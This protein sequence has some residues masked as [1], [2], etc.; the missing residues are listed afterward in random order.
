MSEPINYDKSDSSSLGKSYVAGFLKILRRIKTQG[1][2][3]RDMIRGIITN[4]KYKFVRYFAP[5]YFNMPQRAGIFSQAMIFS[6]ST[7]IMI[8]KKLQILRIKITVRQIL[9]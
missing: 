1:S 9:H 8:L 3:D 7:L 5:Y 6:F 2:I 4:D